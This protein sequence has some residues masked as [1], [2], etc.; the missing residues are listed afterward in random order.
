MRAVGFILA[1]LLLAS[2]SA[3]IISADKA[4][5]VRSLTKRSNFD[6]EIVNLGFE[7]AIHK[8][9]AKHIRPDYTN[10]W[11]RRKRA[12]ADDGS[13]TN[14]GSKDPQPQR[15]DKGASFLHGSNV[16]IDKQN[17]DYLSPPPTDAGVVPNL[18]WSFSLSKTKLLKGGWVREQVVTDLPV[19]KDIAAAE[20]RLAPYAYR[21]LH[22]HRVSEWAFVI[23]GTVRITGNDEDGGNYVADVQAG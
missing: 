15:G 11:Q 13:I 8:R 21:E 9:V 1:A 16:A 17:I 7:S 19:S 4:P 22:W 20:Q 14:F 6:E 18:K 2:A 10:A 12:A 5:Y 23:N 3:R